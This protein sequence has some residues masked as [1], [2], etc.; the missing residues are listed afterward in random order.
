MM[1]RASK[2]IYLWRKWRRARVHRLDE[3]TVR[4]FEAPVDRS[5]L[6]SLWRGS[7][8]SGERALVKQFVRD[9]DR[10]LEAGGGIGVVSMTASRAAGKSGSVLVYEPNF[11]AADAIIA[12]AQENDVVVKVIKGALADESGTGFLSY[13]QSFI[14]GRIAHRESQES[15]SQQVPLYDI[16]AV[17][18][19]YK[20]T[21][22][23]MDVEGME[24]QLV[25]STPLD[26]IEAVITE[27]H[28]SLL[29]AGDLS[30]MYQRLLDNGFLLHVPERSPL[31]V[32]FV[33]GHRLHGAPSSV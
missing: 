14:G 18:S 4:T 32:A 23:V 6:K 13:E 17:V 15:E 24:A 11:K 26:G 2:P 10:V 25:A 1:S 19:E 3:L 31:T 28:P 16:R 8:E 5:I 29:A 9:G 27:I 7:Y 22:L 12:N 33:R 30:K 20:P 21:V